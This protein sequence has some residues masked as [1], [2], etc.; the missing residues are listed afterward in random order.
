M[1]GL[2]EAIEEA[3]KIVISLSPLILGVIPIIKLLTAAF[4][5]FASITLLSLDAII[6][7]IALVFGGITMAIGELIEWFGKAA[8]AFAFLLEKTGQ[9][10]AANDLR[11]FAD[12]VKANGVA[13]TETGKDIAGLGVGIYDTAIAIGKAG[14]VALGAGDDYKGLG[15]AGTIA[16]E[17]IQKTIP[18]FTELADGLKKGEVDAD[19]F[20]ASMDALNAGLDDASIQF[21]IAGQYIKDWGQDLFDSN[22]RAKE[23]VDSVKNLAVELPT[24]TTYIKAGVAEGAE[25]P[26]VEKI[27][28]DT[29]DIQQ[30]IA[31][32]AEQ[33]A[34]EVQ[35]QNT[36]IKL[37]TSGLAPL[38][39]FIAELS[40]ELV[41]SVIDQLGGFGSAAMLKANDEIAKAAAAGGNQLGN[42]LALSATTAQ[43]KFNQAIV[44]LSLE[45]QGLGS[46]AGYFNALSPD[47]FAA[48]WGAYQ[49]ATEDELK[50]YNGLIEKGKQDEAALL[51]AANEAIN[52][53]AE[54]AKNDA[55]QL[56]LDQ[57]KGIEQATIEGEAARQKVLDDAAANA[58]PV[59]AAETAAKGATDKYNAVFAENLDLAVAI[60][61]AI[62]ATSTAKVAI[63]MAAFARTAANYFVA[64]FQG[65]TK[66]DFGSLFAT[67]FFQTNAFS[68][69]GFTSGKDFMSVF[70]PTVKYLAGIYFE[71]LGTSLSINTK[72]ADSAGQAAAV[73]WAKA[74]QTKI[75]DE[76]AL[77]NYGTLFPTNAFSDAGFTSGKDFA[78]VFGPTVKYLAGIYFE[79]L[80]VSLSINTAWAN[81]A[82]Q[83]AAT[84]WSTGFGTKVLETIPLTMTFIA[85]NVSILGAEKLAASGTYL[86]TAVINA[87]ASSLADNVQFLIDTLAAVG[88][89]LAL[90]TTWFS[91]AGG[92]MGST[93]M[94]TLAE[95]I[96]LEIGTATAAIELVAQAI[97]EGFQNTVGP[98][99]SVMGTVLADSAERTALIAKFVGLAV[100]AALAKG[101]VEQIGNSAT[102][103]IGSV[104]TVLQAVL[105]LGPFWT[106]TGKAAGTA[107]AVG[108]SLGML[109]FTALAAVI[110]SAAVIG[111]AASRGLLEATA[112][113][114]RGFAK[115]VAAVISLGIFFAGETFVNLGKSIGYAIA[116]GIAAGMFERLAP[117]KEAAIAIG[118]A[119]A[120]AMREALQINS[121]SRVMSVIGGEVVEGLIVGMEAS[122][123]QLMQTAM[124][125]GAALPTQVDAAASS[126]QTTFNQTTQVDKSTTQINNWNVTT[127]DSMMWAQRTERLLARRRP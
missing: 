72:W 56:A 27:A 53:A 59:T 21:P 67:G 36:I 41:V 45:T 10:G 88:L 33:V 16:G 91:F 86:G 23:L 40:P 51:N 95:A 80:G 50:F 104:V 7:P 111:G 55:I 116:E 84:S 83:A 63:D 115:T 113:G 49:N 64:T 5:G 9:R 24:A 62:A 119:V 13:A 105:R 99:G 92:I 52:K 89:V 32:Q 76:L 126:A 87:L 29:I 97:L 12:S 28:A 127:N 66:V 81:S 44:L 58:D 118:R 11:D 60:E 65:K 93:V 123:P 74:F 90:D 109:D 94:K 4:A 107:Y 3:G 100:A 19:E 125:L 108:V 82:G 15:E 102:L 106:A 96:A 70:G 117:L 1:P 6:G 71:V 73:V 14:G 20:K 79:G 38:G 61:N 85:N 22:A 25:Q 30:A 122:A 103:M 57:N 17:Q 31:L 26:A 69:A 75:V 2:F 110:N 43:N 54:I 98:I 48:Q 77:V 39:N 8:E 112:E 47:E 120:V 37:K 18:T 35:K 34:A 121:P 68:D 78:N 101:F 42:A 114:L 124:L 46:L